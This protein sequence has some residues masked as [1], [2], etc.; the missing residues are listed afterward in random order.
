MW[1]DREEVLVVVVN[2]DRSSMTNKKA[3][4]KQN[5]MRLHD[6]STAHQAAKSIQEEKKP[7]ND[8]AACFLSFK[9]NSKSRK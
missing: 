3:K 1:L 5:Q 9:S 8:L 2:E 4:Q 6:L 7:E